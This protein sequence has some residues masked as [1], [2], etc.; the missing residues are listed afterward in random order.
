MTGKRVGEVSRYFNQISVAVLI[1]SANLKKGDTVHF[2]GHGCDFRQEITSMQIEH[3]IIEA[4]KK[5]D[6]VAVKVDKAVRK[7]TSAYLLSEE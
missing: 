2:L 1:L 5:G 7:G 4:A 6:Q 3:E